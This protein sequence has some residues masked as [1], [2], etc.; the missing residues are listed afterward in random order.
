MAFYNQNQ[1]NVGGQGMNGKPEDEEQQQQG[2][3]PVS[4]STGIVNN[5]APAGAEA[6]KP[7]SSGMAPSFQ[8]YA[9]ANQGAA[10]NNLANA[11]KSNVQHLGQQANTSITQATNR[12]GQKVDAGSLKNRHQAIQD[13]ANAVQAARQITAPQNGP[14]LGA[15]DQNQVNRFQEV[16]NS[17][18]QGPESLRQSGL[19]NNAATKVNTA[20]QAIN[21]AG[22]AQ[23]REELLRS[24][25]EKRGD[26][27]RGQNKLD[28]ALLNSSKAGVSGLQNAA[29]QQGNLRNTLDKAQLA[30]GNLAQNRANEIRGIQE[31][32]RNT[33]T[34]GKK[35]EEA[36]TEKRLGAVIQDWDKLPEH[37]KELIRNKGTTSQ[38]ILDEQVAKFKTEKGYDALVGQRSNL[39]KASREAKNALQMDEAFGGLL[40]KEADIVERYNAHKAAADKNS[41]TMKNG[42]VASMTPVPQD[43]ENEYKQL[44]QLKK[45]KNT[46][47][48]YDQLN[49]QVNALTNEL[50]TLT[51]NFNKD[52]VFLNPVEAAILGIQSGEGFYNLGE[53]AIKTAAA[54]KSRLVSKDEQ[55]R[56]AALAA[57]AGLDQSNRLDRNL[58]YSDA[59]KAGTQSAMDAL[60]LEGT[61]KAITDAENSF[62]NTAEGTNLT[63]HG[64][65]KV[66]RGNAFGKK[67]KTYT[68]SVGGNAGDFL[69]EAGYDF[70]A[71][72]AQDSTRGKDLLQAALRASSTDRNNADKEDAQKTLTTM[73]Q[74]AAAGASVGS[75]GGGVG[76]GI[77]AA[78]GAS[79]GAAAGSGTID[80]TQTQSDLLTAFAPELGN[81][82]QDHRSNAG[83]AARSINKAATLGMG[84]VVS[85]SLGLGDL[86]SHIGGA[87][88]GINS[89]AMRAFGEAV[90]KD[91]A[92]ADLKRQ[93]EGFLKGQG[94]DNRANVIN[95]AP[96]NNRLSALQAL[97]SKLDKTNT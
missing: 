14:A 48:N 71:P 46:A 92:V 37:F 49:K 87:I 61:R 69:K 30:S 55:A 80:S 11:A 53:N 47:E 8:S 24:M 22:T 36:D 9:K 84:D 74:G 79:L 19:Y 20:T 70:D 91:H 41:F 45:Y 89:G 12:F 25:Y 52:A 75:L 68:A 85:N 50:G 6:P 2:T 76:A 58:L 88:G 43:I 62:Q 73:G 16:I 86:S 34:Q 82:F 1:N 31:Q 10:T 60:D 83:N 32:A 95:A 96:V 38:K 17:R 66:S 97:L 23:G 18:Y 15:M 29:Q 3:A 63:G 93:Y 35:A 33:F 7:A 90:A 54:D 64:V 67:T 56:Q 39:E 27:T 81:A 65:K 57:L 26:Y 78:I 40:S 94:F 13:V 42:Q 59:S 5:A 28:T 77:G 72:V 44:Q 51:G 4:L 21:N